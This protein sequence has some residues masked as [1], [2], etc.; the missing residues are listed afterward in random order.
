MGTSEHGKAHGDLPTS[1]DAGSVSA[2]S[3][4]EYE[5]Y[6]EPEDYEYDDDMPDP[7]AQPSVQ[8]GWGRLSV[9]GSSRMP[10]A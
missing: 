9:R 1:D 7:V 10:A 5:Y 3:S 6:S 2:A 4:E 8:V